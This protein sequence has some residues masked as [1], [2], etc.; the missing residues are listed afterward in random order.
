ME[1]CIGRYLRL[2]DVPDI[3]LGPE[4]ELLPVDILRR[5]RIV[6]SAE[7]QRLAFGRLVETILGQKETAERVRQARYEWENKK[8]FLWGKGQH[9]WVVRGPQSCYKL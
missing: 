1:L 3:I 7:N 2:E 9:Y 4:Q 5:R 8:C 6:A